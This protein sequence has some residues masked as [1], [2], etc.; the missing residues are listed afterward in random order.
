[1]QRKMG[2]DWKHIKQLTIH[3]EEGFELSCDGGSRK[4]KYC[5]QHI[6]FWSEIHF[7]QIPIW[8]ISGIDFW[9]SLF[10]RVLPTHLAEKYC[11]MAPTPG[12][13]KWCSYLCTILYQLDRVNYLTSLNLIFVLYKMKMGQCL[14]YKAVVEI[15]WEY[16]CKALSTPYM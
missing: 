8:K 5:V 16:S 9:T 1:M 4:E 15:K 13:N 14:I 11:V 12:R 6:P 2:R 7:F 3:A 10:S